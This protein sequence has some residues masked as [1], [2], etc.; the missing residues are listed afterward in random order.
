MQLQ[1][2][3]PGFNLR[4][5]NLR[6]F[7]AK[8]LLLLAANTLTVAFLHAE[9][10]ITQSQMKPAERD[11]IAA[12]ARTLATLVE[13]NDAPGLRQQTLAE[14]AKDF[15]GMTSLVA[16]TSTKI[17]GASL[18]VDQ[19][20]LLDAS[21]L[22]TLGD[23]TNQDAQFFCSLNKSMAEANFLIPALPPGRYAFAIV[24]AQGINAP[25]RLSFLLKQ[26]APAGGQDGSWSMAGF[27]PKPLT[28]AGHDGIWYWT[29]ARDRVK[30]RQLWAAYLYYQQAQ[31]LLQPAGFVTSSHFD[32]L[33][34][35]TTSTAPPALSDGISADAPLVVK[36]KGGREFRFTDLTTDDSL[37]ADKVDV[38]AHLAPEP[39]S[40]ASST[41][42]SAKSKS[43]PEQKPDPKSPAAL[44]VLSP[45]DRNTA[46][47]AALIAAFPELRS[48][49]HGVWIFADSPGQNPFI[50]EQPMA[51][52][53]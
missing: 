11:A 5:F 2:S 10:C 6:G 40:E 23:G 45:R 37:S 4:G 20:Y 29:Q 35:E 1:H 18:S 28:A 21:S 32:K 19:V 8:V 41:A 31:A 17:K 22:K 50:T 38:V 49:F 53:P 46:A 14:Y 15:S 44:P 13:T 30:A 3:L 51:N 7:S 25:W 48:T 42:D 34:R 16:N 12:T 36:G 27:Y 9:V 33:R 26:N 52:I 24:N 39:P 43:K 47:M